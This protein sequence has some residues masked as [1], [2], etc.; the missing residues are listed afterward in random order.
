MAWT[1]FEEVTCKCFHCF[2][3]YE[4]CYKKLIKIIKFLKLLQVGWYQQLLKNSHWRCLAQFLLTLHWSYPMSII[5]IN[6]FNYL[7]TLPSHNRRRH[8]CEVIRTLLIDL[9]NK[10]VLNFQTSNFSQWC[11]LPPLLKS[12][13]Y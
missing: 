11:V 3:H 6:L 2:T 4:K 8:N 9:Q 5:Y 13:I 12:Q 10:K 7:L 1:F